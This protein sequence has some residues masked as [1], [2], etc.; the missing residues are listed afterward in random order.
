METKKAVLIV[1]HGSRSKDAVAEFHQVVDAVSGRYK[2]TKVKGAFMELSEPDIPT[3]VKELSESGITEIAVIPYFLFMGN[4]IKQDIPEIL[5]EQRAL[6]PH[7]NF[8]FGRP[9]GFEPLLSDILI[10]R[11][12]EVEAR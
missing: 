9:I 7:L 10:Q 8:K 2:T 12:E 1:S 11:I 5:E 6:Y 4:H 3:A